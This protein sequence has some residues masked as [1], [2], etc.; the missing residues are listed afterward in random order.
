MWYACV[1]CGVVW[2]GCVVSILFSS[3]EMVRSIP[4][5][6]PEKVQADACRV[7]RPYVRNPRVQTLR[8]VVV[9]MNL[10]LNLQG[11]GVS[12]CSVRAA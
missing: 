8:A 6:V 3:V 10:K 1:S 9:V 11:D 2:C 5:S 12:S 7:S 4:C